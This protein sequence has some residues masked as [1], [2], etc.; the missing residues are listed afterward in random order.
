MINTIERLRADIDS[1][2]TADKVAASDPASAPLGADDEAAGK[3]ARVRAVRHA[4]LLEIAR[5]HERREHGGLGHAW[6]LVVFTILLAAA[7]VIWGAAMSSH[8]FRAG[9]TAARSGIAI[10]P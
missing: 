2:R 10:L 1:G 3:P 9:I 4:T 7:I 6:I 8:V 5:P